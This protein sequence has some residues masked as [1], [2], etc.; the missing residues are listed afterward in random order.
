[1]KSTQNSK[2]HKISNILNK[3][4]GLSTSS[5]MSDCHTN[6]IFKDEKSIEILKFLDLTDFMSKVITSENMLVKD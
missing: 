6:K 1:M 5:E 2:N 3:N 4:L